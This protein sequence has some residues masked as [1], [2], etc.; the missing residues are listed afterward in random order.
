M[1]CSHTLSRPEDLLACANITRYQAKCFA[2]SVIARSWSP[3]NLPIVNTSS[4]RH[5]LNH[6]TSPLSPKNSVNRS[7]P[8]ADMCRRS[9]QYARY[10]VGWLATALN[11]KGDG[12]KTPQ[13]ESASVGRV[14]LPF[15]KAGQMKTRRFLW[16][17]GWKML[18]RSEYTTKAK[19]RVAT[20]GWWPQSQPHPN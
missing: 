17:L 13:D 7:Y 14:M 19:I 8:S 9:G 5:W 12:R 1:K 20:R 11:D 3:P 16:F 18:R 2:D 4:L 6:V 10:L 15:S